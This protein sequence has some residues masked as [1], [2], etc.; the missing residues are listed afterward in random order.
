MLTGKACRLIAGSI[1][2]VHGE[3]LQGR[4]AKIRQTS[5]SISQGKIA[6]TALQQ[7]LLPA[8]QPGSLHP[9]REFLNTIQGIVLRLQG[10]QDSGSG[11]RAIAAVSA[12]W[13]S[14][15]RDLSAPRRACHEL[16]PRTPPLAGG[17]AAAAAQSIV[18]SVSRVYEGSDARSYA[19]SIS[20][21]ARG[22][23]IWPIAQC[24]RWK[25]L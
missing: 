19:R 14:A 12:L 25:S 17:P 1:L 18:R 22:G 10:M 20:P 3:T 4:T 13:L 23:L 7:R 24:A 11:R 5:P 9:I 2:T 6:R 8:L 16:R 15:D 21:D